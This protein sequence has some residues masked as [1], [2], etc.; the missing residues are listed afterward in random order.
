MAAH[1]LVI[2]NGTVVDGTGAPRR[3]ADVAVDG[4]RIVAVGD[5]EGRGRREL[6]ADGLLVTPGW[7]DVHTHYDGQATW[8]PQLTPSSWHGV[9]TV[10]MGNCGVGFAPVAPD[11]HEWLVALM[12]GVEDIPGTAL[13]EGITWEWESFPEYLDALGRTPK[14]IDLAAQVPHAALRGYVMGDRGAEH[15]ELPTPDEIDRMGRL[16]AE[17][18]EAGALGFTTSRTIAH[19]SVDGR[20][21][22]SLTATADE[23]LGIA[24]AV[25][26]TGKGVFQAVADLVDVDVE[27]ALLRAMA[28]VSGRPLSITTLQR[29]EQSPDAY[30]RLLELI[31]AAAADGLEVRGQVASRPVGL[32]LSLEGRLHPLV[33]SPTYQAMAERPLS[34]RVA[35][36]RRPEVRERVLGELADPATDIVGRLGPTFAFGDEPR[37]DPRPADRLDLAA[38][39]DALLADEGRGVLYVPIM[40]FTD[41]DLAAVREM[42]VH[43]RTVPGLGD[44][45][46]H[47][48]MICDASFPTHLL[49]YWGRDVA[50]DQRLGV[51]WVVARQAAATA[52]LVGL[53]DRGTLQV[54]KRADVNLIDL[55]ALTLHNPEMRYDLPAGGKRLVQRVDGYRA[56]IVAGEVVRA[57]GEDTGALPG[58]L[59]RGARPA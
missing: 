20:P 15:A 47:C 18:I 37:Y 54:G 10:V 4:G 27:F 1:D 2:R 53:G 26:A 23:L 44:A 48:T 57:D 45:G 29:A 58:Q 42:L 30:R 24:R 22:P 12:E 3:E 14:A 31:A 36:L 28:E 11:R 43:P 49:Q 19:R 25:G 35:E 9:T 8:D 46:A 51:E 32:V 17:A 59:V 55:D 39:Y 21:T 40:N 33:A 50:E 13:H 56:T 38:A 52:A 16:A 6:E 5:V 34:E 41:G 7:V